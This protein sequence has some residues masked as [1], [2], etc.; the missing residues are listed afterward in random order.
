MKVKFFTDVSF[1]NKKVSPRDIRNIVM[2]NVPPELADKIGNKGKRKHTQSV[3]VYP[4]PRPRSFEILSYLNDLKALAA[5]EVALVGKRFNLGGTDVKIVSCEWEDED[6]I[7]VKPDL[8]MYKTRTP[9]VISSNPVEH[10]IVYASTR[11]DN[12]LPYIQKK[13]VEMIKIQYKE[14]FNKNLVLND[15]ILK[16]VKMNKITVTIDQESKKYSQAV[17][18]TF[19]SNYRLPRFIGFNNGLGFGEI[20]DTA[21]LYQK[22]KRG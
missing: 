4:K 20:Y 8:V 19:I 16:I 1:D 21:K 18:A 3:F 6:Y 12:L 13:I 9:I 11:N 10:K 22:N 7:S 17:Y 2:S 15:L 14:F 5:A